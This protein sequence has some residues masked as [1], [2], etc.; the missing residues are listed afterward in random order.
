MGNVSFETASKGKVWTFGG[1]PTDSS[2]K[3]L[4]MKTL[5]DKEPDDNR[6]IGAGEAT[7]KD[8]EWQA[9]HPNDTM[10]YLN[11]T[12][13]SAPSRALTEHEK[14]LISKGQWKKPITEMPNTSNIGAKSRQEL[15]ILHAKEDNLSKDQVTIKP[16]KPPTKDLSTYLREQ[17]AIKD[18][19]VP[20]DQLTPEQQYQRRLWQ[21]EQSGGKST[22]KSSKSS[23]GFFD[24]L[25]SKI[26]ELLTPKDLSGQ[27]IAVNAAGF[28]ISGITKSLPKIESVKKALSGL[29]SVSFSGLKN[30]ISGYIGK[31]DE[32][33]RQNPTVKSTLDKINT[34]SYDGIKTSIGGYI[35][36]FDESIKQNPT[37]KSTLETINDVSYEGIKTSIGGYISKF[38][39]SIKQSPTVKSALDTINGISYDSLKQTIQGYMDKFTETATNM[40]GVKTGL[41]IINGISYESLKTTIQGV[42][43][44]FTDTITNSNLV[45]IAISTWNSISFGG[46]TSA[47]NAVKSTINTVVEAAK[48]MYYTV[49]T[50]VAKAKDYISGTNTAAAYSAS[51]MTASEKATRAANNTVYN[52]SVNVGTINNNGSNINSTKTTLAN[53]SRS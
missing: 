16:E 30:S 42:I 14:E 28:D 53:I 38:D 48:N 26:T 9:T 25:W 4:P 50:Y 6:R 18:K 10:L 27:P 7:R 34:V 20:D 40:P 45:K 22:L 39:E 3:T 29:N 41:E 2:G 33:I 1:T 36:K 37:V 43:N 51:Q 21:S 5:A 35:D 24:G 44:K 13:G 49:M 15:N 52:N 12:S 23:T 47:I 31:F 19:N 8:A 11:K 32:S 46:L 17:H